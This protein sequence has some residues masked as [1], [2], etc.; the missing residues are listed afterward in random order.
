[1]SDSDIK[2]LKKVLARQAKHDEKNLQRARQ[3]LAK[4]EKAYNKSKK[5]TAKARDELQKTLKQQATTSKDLES[6]HKKQTKAAE[7]LRKVEDTYQEK[8]HH[9]SLRFQDVEKVQE[10]MSESY[11]VK[12]AN[13][14]DRERQ[15]AS[16]YISMRRQ[17]VAEENSNSDRGPVTS[18]APPADNGVQS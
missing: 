17:Q 4:V 18:F 6:A 14:Q 16:A 10:Q 11:R 9:E 5:D 8:R 13:D 3:D 2:G 15:K 1:M 7:T 12:A